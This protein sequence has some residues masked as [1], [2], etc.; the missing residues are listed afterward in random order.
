MAKY[1]ESVKLTW[2]ANCVRWVF[3]LG[4]SYPSYWARWGAFA[5]G[6]VIARGRRPPVPSALQRINSVQFTVALVVIEAIAHDE[7]IFDGEADEI[8]A[9]L[10]HP[11]GRL[12]E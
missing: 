9:Y 4:Y 10:A 8:C 5:T 7:V 1:L 2:T 6:V 3:F 12:V 11:A